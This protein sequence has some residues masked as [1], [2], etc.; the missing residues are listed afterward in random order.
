[1]QYG[2]LLLDTNVNMAEIHDLEQICSKVHEIMLAVTKG[3]PIP[4]K[5]KARD[6][7][8]KI[9]VFTYGVVKELSADHSVHAD[10]VYLR[11]L[12]GGGLNAEQAHIIVD[13]TRDE[14]TQ[15]EF[16]QECMQL[17]KDVTHKWQDGNKDIEDALR[18]L[19]V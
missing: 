16:G 17:A 12:M 19:I 4:D 6:V 9:S 18:K 10:D 15:R 14:F 11:Y 1:M 5:N 13:R 8:K 7:R 3:L 2:W